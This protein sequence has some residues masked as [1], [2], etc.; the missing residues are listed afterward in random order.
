MF[1]Q[2]YSLLLSRTHSEV[3]RMNGEGPLV[4]VMAGSP[5]RI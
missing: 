1:S 3:S 5:I 4:I 2:V